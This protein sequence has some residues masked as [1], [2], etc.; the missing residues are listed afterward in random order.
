MTTW[1]YAQLM[2]IWIN[3]GGATAMAPLM[4]AVAEVESGGNDQ[5]TNPSGAT[6]LWQIEWPLHQG[7][8]ACATS[9]AALLDPNCNAKAAIAI[10][11]NV[12]STAPGSPVYDN[13]LEDE[14]AGAYKAFISGSTTPDTNAGGGAQA[15]TTAASTANPDCLWQFDIPADGI[16]I[17]GSAISKDTTFCIL[18]KSEARAMIGGMLMVGS[19]IAALVGLV[20]L[21]AAA[22]NRTGALAKTAQAAAVV[23]G[24]GVVA[25]PLRRAHARA[26]GQP[27]RARP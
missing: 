9:Q 21:A 24:G 22:F 17:I 5:A 13:W 25:A 10:S 8:V 23:P 1:T 2:G 18:S 11:G 12:N 27:Q 3:N 14:P 4:A 15:T 6:G 7:I 19:G 20:I 16:P 26:S